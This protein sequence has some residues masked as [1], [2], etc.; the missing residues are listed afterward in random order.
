MGPMPRSQKKPPSCPFCEKE[1][2][3]AAFLAG[4]S[5]YDASVGY[6]CAACPHCAKPIEFGVRTST[7]L[8]G[9]TYWAGALHFEPMIEYAVPGLRID[10]RDGPVRISIR[11][12]IVVP[13]DA[14]AK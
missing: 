2:D 5:G 13:N 3:A 10:H 11:G 6:G 7:L 1:L 9:Y 14:G 4:A 12:R 8:F